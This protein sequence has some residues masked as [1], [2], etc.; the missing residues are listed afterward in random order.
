MET[1]DYKHLLLAVDF[2]KESEPVIA[3]AVW[4]QKLLGA[5]LTLLHVTEHIPP[6]MDYMS[7]GYSGDIALP[8]NAALEKELIELVKG[9]LDSLGDRISVPAEDR[10]V[11]IGP[12]GHIIDTV[13]AELGADLVVIGSHGRHGLMGLFGSTAKSVL[14]ELTCDLLVVKIGPSQD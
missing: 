8:E 6:A 5:R 13:A 9:Q 10:L 3:R 2:E 11:R 14:R 1:M 4:L 12:T 7:L